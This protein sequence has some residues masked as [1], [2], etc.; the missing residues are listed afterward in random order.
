MTENVVKRRPRAV[1]FKRLDFLHTATWVR[2]ERFPVIPGVMPETN[3]YR[4]VLFLSNFDGGWDAYLDAFLDAFGPGIATLWA[5]SAGFPP[6]PGRGS[7]YALLEWLRTRLVDSLHYYAAFPEASTHDIRSALRVTRE[8][9]ALVTEHAGHEPDVADPAHVPAARWLQMVTRLQSCLSQS[10]S[11]APKDAITRGA[12]GLSNLVSLSPVIPGHEDELRDAIAALNVGPSPFAGVPGTHFARLALIDRLSAGVHPDDTI[13]LNN[14]W[15][16]FGADFDGW[17]PV[18]EDSSPRAPDEQLRR[19][20][21]LVDR[22]PRLKAIWNEHCYG[23]RESD[24][25]ASYLLPTVVKRFVLF[26]D[27]GSNTVQDVA[28]ALAV[29]DKVRQAALHR[30]QNPLVT[31][32]W[33]DPV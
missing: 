31:D 2:V 20:F 6:F 30:A 14:S 1:Q 3:K 11:S 16:L 33:P 26:R 27:Y 5:T 15:L 17:F 23:A 32:L 21:D 22:R 8:V 10:A 29:Q 25:L 12:T 24:S 28:E 19:Y 18:D 7:R 13:E 9:G 4:W